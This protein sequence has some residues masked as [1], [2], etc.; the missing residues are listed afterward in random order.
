MP[1]ISSGTPRSWLSHPLFRWSLG[2]FAAVI[3]GAGL[4]QLFHI[5]IFQSFG[6]AHQFCYSNDPTLIWLQVVSDLA[7]GLAYVSI[8][9][10]L[11]YLVYRG[12]KGIPFHWVF[13]AF[14]LFIISCGLTHFMEVWVIWKPLYWLSGYVKVITAC[15]SVA[16]AIA[17]F[18]LV[19]KVL[20]LIEAARQGEQRRIEIEQ[21]NQELERFN[22]SVAHDLRSPLR[23]MSGYSSALL[24]DYRH[25]MPKEAVVYAEKINAS[26]GRMDGLINDLLRYA[27]IGRSEIALEEVP[28]QRPINAALELLSETIQNAKAHVNIEGTLPTV[29]GDSALLQV[30]FQNLIS[31][32]LKFVEEGKFPVVLIS[33]VTK[34]KTATIYVTDNGIGMPSSARGK[35]FRMFERFNR[36]YP[37]TGMGLAI[38]QRAVERMKGRIGL[39]D[40]TSASGT[41]FWIQLPRGN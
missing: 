3:A 27:I 22:Y 26:V 19:P 11:A 32:S 21:L 37:G 14:G 33:A 23:S 25:H 29:I 34:E 39:S 9:A 16:T 17:L 8:S 38:V 36:N 18:P 13:L 24:E 1:A 30:V 6:F 20:A 4:F 40:N 41:E 10:T 2:I 5:S 15:A 35:L 7:I 28:L 12:S 31:N